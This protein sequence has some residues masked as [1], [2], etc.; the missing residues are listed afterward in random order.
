MRSREYFQ[1][2]FDQ[3][4]QLLTIIDETIDGSRV[5]ARSGRTGTAMSG[6]SP[7]GGSDTSVFTITQRFVDTGDT[8]MM[9]RKLG[10]TAA[11]FARQ[12]NRYASRRQHGT[13]HGIQR[14]RTL[15]GADARVSNV[16]GALRREV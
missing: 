14:M 3:P 16:G 4:L 15:G 11:N 1:A 12:S 9:H 7:G 2:A 5:R 8:P 13:P 10:G 6:V